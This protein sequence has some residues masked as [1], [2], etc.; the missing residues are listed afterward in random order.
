MFR[1]LLLVI[2]FRLSTVR[3]GNCKLSSIVVC[4]VVASEMSS[5]K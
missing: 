5:A 2:G 4:V 3:F 1:F